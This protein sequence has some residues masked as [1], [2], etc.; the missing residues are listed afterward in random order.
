MIPL[1]LGSPGTRTRCRRRSP[2][3]ITPLLLFLLLL[4]AG[5]AAGQLELEPRVF[6][7]A[8][9]LRCPVCTSES[10]AQS[11]AETSVRMREIIAEKLRAGESEAQILAYFQER[12]GDWIL[13]EPPRSGIYLAVWIFPVLASA[14]LLAVLGYYL[15]QWTIRGRQSLN[16]DADYLERVQRNLQSATAEAEESR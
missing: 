7:I 16:A 3:S 9:K 12:Y 8:A 10:V 15:R 1:V 6:E 5:T 11:A 14:L 4:L 13:L 2:T